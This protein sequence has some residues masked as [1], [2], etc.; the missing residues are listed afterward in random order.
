MK[1]IEG[2]KSVDFEITAL[3]HGVVNWNGPTQLS[4]EG[5]VVD[6]HTLPKL[7]GYTNLTG[8][9]KEETGYKYKKEATDMDFTKTPLY[10]SQNCIRHH[11]FRDQAFD[12]H[13]AKEKDLTPV[14]ASITGLMRGFVVPSS[15][16]KR[17]S[18]LLIEDFV[19]ELGNGNFDQFGQAGERDSSSFFSK[20]TFGDTKYTAYGSISIEQLQFISLDNK[21][22]RAAMIIK[23]DQGEKVAEQVQEFI[24]RIKEQQQ[25]KDL[26]PKAVFHPNYVRGGTI[27]EEGEQGILLNQDAIQILVNETLEML[28]NL[29]IRQAK[30]YMYVDKLEVDYNDSTKMMRVKR[31]D[32]TNPEKDKEFAIYFYAKD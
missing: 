8:R 30:G 26:N 27:F 3:G 18:P 28:K 9:I 17:T 2:I 11:L 25:L 1:N 23:E 19:D 14:L 21:F 10:I 13:F 29:N 12:L 15:Q 4:N 32:S 6:N 24:Q 5:K 31:G 20:T 22:D 16:C 7:R